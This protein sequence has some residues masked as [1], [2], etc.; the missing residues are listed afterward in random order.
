MLCHAMLCSVALCHDLL[1]SVTICYDLL[2]SATICYDPQR[3]VTLG[4]ARLRSVTLGYARL[5]SITLD[6]ARL[7]SVPIVATMK[8]R[9]RTMRKRKTVI[10]LQIDF[11]QLTPERIKENDAVEYIEERYEQ[12]RDAL[13]ELR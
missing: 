5:R 3:S 2:R 13:T 10:M 7:R 11:Q 1:R 9:L 12:I 6:Y 8:V 4:C